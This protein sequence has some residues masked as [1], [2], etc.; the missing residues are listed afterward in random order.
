MKNV[1]TKTENSN[2]EANLEAVEANLDEVKVFLGQYSEAEQEAFLEVFRN[3]D[4][5][6][7]IVLPDQK[8]ENQGTDDF[9]EY[10]PIRQIFHDLSGREKAL[11]ALN[12]SLICADNCTNDARARHLRSI[13]EEAIE[14]CQEDVKSLV[15]N[16]EFG[17]IA[18]LAGV[19]EGLVN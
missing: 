13:Q 6:R 15:D 1:E 3:I 8:T 17:T 11:L 2:I 18:L 14:R 9:P 12:Q 16:Q 10:A 5:Y 4:S 7:H 19:I